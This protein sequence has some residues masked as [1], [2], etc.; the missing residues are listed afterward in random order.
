[1]LEGIKDDI[2]SDKRY[3]QRKRKYYETHRED[4][5]AVAG[6]L[7]LPVETPVRAVATDD[8]ID[9]SVSGTAAELKECFRAFRKLGYEP[10][11]R[12]RF[13]LFFS[14]TVCTLKKVGT[15]MVEQAVYETVCE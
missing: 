11:D 4:V 6:E 9:L 5:A 7:N 8:S 2:K 10:N 13:W 3:Y 12:V 1:M 14:S 15:K